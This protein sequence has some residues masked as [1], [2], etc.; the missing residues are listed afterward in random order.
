MI[1]RQRKVAMLKN[2]YDNCKPADMD[3]QCPFG[4]NYGYEGDPIITK[5]PCMDLCGTWVQLGD[6]RRGCPCH[7]LGRN[8]ALIQLYS[9]LKEEGA[10]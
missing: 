1:S 2:F 7:T 6:V 8:T 3:A 9:I 5:M 10:I 4:K